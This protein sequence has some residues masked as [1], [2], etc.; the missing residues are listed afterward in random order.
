MSNSEQEQ[1]WNRWE[2]NNRRGKIAGGVLIVL[3][4]S[5]YLARELGA[6][7]PYWVFS[8]KM[9]LIMMGLV[10]GIKSSFKRPMWF[11]LYNIGSFPDNPFS[12]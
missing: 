7:I 5:L 9:F 1:I 8:W 6:M 2:T 3:L 12:F 4:G 10:V 11:V